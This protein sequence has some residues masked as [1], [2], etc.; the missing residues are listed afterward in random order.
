MTAYRFILSMS[1]AGASQGHAT[2]TIAA[3]WTIDYHFGWWHQ[4]R[5]KS[6]IEKVGAALRRQRAAHGRLLMGYEDGPLWHNG[7][8]TEPLA[9]DTVVRIVYEAKPA[10]PNVKRLTWGDEPT[11]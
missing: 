10:D 3:L 7:I 1:M 6:R 2:P 11:E 5:S 4:M 9:N 8:I